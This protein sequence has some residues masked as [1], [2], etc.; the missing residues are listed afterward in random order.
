LFSGL[1]EESLALNHQREQ[2]RNKK[3]RYITNVYR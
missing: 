3:C 2:R 1:I